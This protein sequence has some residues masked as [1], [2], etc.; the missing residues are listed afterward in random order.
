MA[1]KIHVQTALTC[2]LS[3]FLFFFLFSFPLMRWSNG[4]HFCLTHLSWSSSN[5]QR[6]RKW[7]FPRAFCFGVFLLHAYHIQSL[8]SY[9][10][11]KC[12]W[13]SLVKEGWRLALYSLGFFGGGKLGNSQLAIPRFPE[14]QI[15]SVASL[16]PTGLQVN[17]KSWSRMCK[18]G[19][20]GTRKDKRRKR[21]KGDSVSPKMNRRTWGNR[22]E[23]MRDVEISDLVSNLGTSS[24]NVCI[25]KFLIWLALKAG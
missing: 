25:H 4:Q 15:W 23:F 21:N 2:F 20:Q 1:L 24:K 3:F 13:T 9:L 18:V 5:S 16:N 14:W 11:M 12:I 7:P 10:A 8:V 19:W 17:T 6:L 22:K